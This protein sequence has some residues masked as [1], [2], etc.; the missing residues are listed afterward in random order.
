MNK[1]GLSEHPA[2]KLAAYLLLPVL[3]DAHLVVYLP[4]VIPDS[5][6]LMLRTSGMLIAI[7]WGWAGLFLC[8][9]LGILIGLP[10]AG[11]HIAFLRD[12]LAQV[13]RGADV[14]STLASFEVWAITTM[15]WFLMAAVAYLVGYF[16]LFPPVGGAILAVNVLWARTLVYNQQLWVYEYH[17]AYWQQ[18]TNRAPSAA[19]S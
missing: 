2:I 5:S 4:Y 13:R 3:I 8:I 6:L 16:W 7:S 12:R 1:L 9:L 15:P 11:F 10:V 17:R 14:P 19:A 18:Q